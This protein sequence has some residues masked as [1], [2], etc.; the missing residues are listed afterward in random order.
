[1]KL[2]L[3]IIQQPMRGRNYL[4]ALLWSLGL[5][6]TLL[7]TPILTLLAGEEDQIYYS[8]EVDWLL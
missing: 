3:K 8:V 6:A 1:M 7:L 4:G 2:V 5:P